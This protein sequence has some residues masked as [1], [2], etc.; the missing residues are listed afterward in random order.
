V[1]R[2]SCRHIA[3]GRR[4]RATAGDSAVASHHVLRLMDVWAARAERQ[5]PNEYKDIDQ[6]TR[7][8]CLFSANERG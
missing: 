8:R 1:A 7:G 6:S 5:L 4:R 3:R 2:Q